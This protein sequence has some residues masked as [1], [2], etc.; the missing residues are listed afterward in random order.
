MKTMKD[1][2][3]TLADKLTRFLLSYRITPHTVTGCIPAELL[4]GRRIRTRLDICI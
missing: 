4:M 3:E 1:E 2:P